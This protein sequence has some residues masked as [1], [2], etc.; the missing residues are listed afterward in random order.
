[1]LRFVSLG[2][3]ALALMAG[4]FASAQTADWQK[5]Y[6]ISGKA[7]LTLGIGDA[8]VEVRSCNDCREVRIRLEWRDRK[9]GDFIL[10]EF[11]SGDHVNFELKEKPL[12]IHWAMG[13]IR[14]PQLTVETPAA[15][16]LEARTADGGLK[17]SG[18]RGSLELHTDDGSVD[19]EDV[20]G[21]VR[22]TAGDGSVKIHNVT[23]TLESRSSDGQAT[24]EG[25]FTALQVH[26][27]DGNLDLTVADGSLL[28]TASRIE[29]SDGR[30]TVRLPRTLA[31]DLDVHTSDGH[32][33]CALP[34]T[35]DG[36]NS[37]H[38]SGHNLRGHL[39]G[40]GVPLTVHTSDGNVAIQTL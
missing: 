18:V 34:L 6:P 15:L 28:N 36:F 38:G 22:L 4:A 1:M 23:G 26:T 24:V 35:M 11:Q 21:A 13:R 14:E 16:D 29:S 2:L 10:N 9:P 33:D 30:V 39:N 12:G 31:V 37:A 20:A 5:S 25:K 32:I 27:S 40:G 3:P 7:S 8:S 17:V 19:V